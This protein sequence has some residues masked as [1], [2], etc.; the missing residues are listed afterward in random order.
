[1][2][3]RGREAAGLSKELL[4]RSARRFVERVVSPGRGAVES[5]ETSSRASNRSATRTR[6]GRERYAEFKARNA[7]K[8][9]ALYTDERDALDGNAAANLEERRIDLATADAT[10]EDLRSRSLDP[11]PG[12]RQAS[13]KSIVQAS[14]EL[15]SLR[16]RYTDE[17]SEVQAAERKLSDWRKSEPVCWQH[18]PRE[19][20]RH[21]EAVEHR[22]RRRT[23][24]RGFSPKPCRL[25][26][27]LG[28]RGW[29]RRS[30]ACAWVSLMGTSECFKATCLSF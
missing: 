6:Q 16:A 13:E 3:I 28:C 22:R 27:A 8:L 15:A 24:D 10:F 26:D 9:P 12:R 30:G 2:K 20:R 1:M 14:G 18:Q 11:E 7:D 4:V 19:R 17:H 25:H 5:S 23:L 21:A 29:C